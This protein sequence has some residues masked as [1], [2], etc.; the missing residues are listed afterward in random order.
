MTIFQLIETF[1]DPILST[2]F[3]GLLLS[4]VAILFFSI[5]LGFL[6]IPKV[7]ILITVVVLLLMFVAFGWIPLWIIILLTLTFFG[8][9]L[10]NMRGG[11][12]V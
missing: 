8:L 9:F 2:E 5:A 7:S 4:F 12:N 3:G 6:N 11:S 1:L 10:L